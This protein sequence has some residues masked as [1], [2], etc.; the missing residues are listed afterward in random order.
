MESKLHAIHPNGIE[1]W[2]FVYE[3]V[4]TFGPPSIHTDGTIYVSTFASVT[5]EGRIY[6]INPDGTK[7]WIY[8]TTDIPHK[9]LAIG[10]D[11]TLFFAGDK[12]FYA[13]GADGKLKWKFTLTAVVG[14]GAS[15]D[16]DGT[17]YFPAY[18]NTDP[19]VGKLYSLNPD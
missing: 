11:G 2:G 3:G 4:P 18:E 17:V 13:L 16:Y 15:I 10:G 7:K 8:I 5:G 12:A 6:A 1:K 9:H 19:P 14:Y